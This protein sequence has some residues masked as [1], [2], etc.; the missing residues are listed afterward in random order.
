MH[1]SFFLTGLI[2]LT[3]I[4]VTACGSNNSS[5]PSSS[6]PASSASPSNE[7]T[8][9]ASSSDDAS[10]S[11]TKVT[12]IV[13]WFPQPEHGGQFAALM[14]GFYKD[15]GLD[16]T[17]EPGG[18][19]INPVQLLSS[20]KVQFAMMKADDLLM[21]REAGVPVVGLAGIFQKTPQALM[22]HKEEPIK[23]FS[24][25]NGRKVYTQPGIAYWEYIKNRYKLD[26]VQ[27][28]V[29]NGQ[30]ANFTADKKSVTQV[31]G[32]NEPFYVMQEGVEV[33]LLWIADSGY[34]PYD[35]I[36]ITT[37]S[38]IKDHP[39]I[40][41]AYVEASIKGWD[42]YKDHYEEVNPFIKEK[43]PDL[44]AEAMTYAS[45]TM[46]DLVYGGDAAVNGTGYM[47]KEHWETMMKQMLELKLLKKEQDVTKA[48]TTEFL[49][50]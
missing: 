3:V 1:K 48:F 40:V 41:K 45:K 19:Q 37:E 30:M 43:N 7:P 46:E 44:N 47:S 36:L 25:L 49:P 34:A 18:P 29:Y 6:A 31:Y 22:Y 42:Y 32:T 23:D 11:L 16:M 8:T 33:G 5:A 13:G 17:I 12:Q 14:K 15:A 28:M 35:N 39:D 21:A 38:Y 50:K 9:S 4:A 26:K 10:K 20:G 2:L 24:D 27:D